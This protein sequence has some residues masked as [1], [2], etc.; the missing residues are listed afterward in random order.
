MGQ[1]QEDTL[2]ITLLGA[3]Q[4]VPV[5]ELAMETS[6][7]SDR[8]LRRVSISFDVAAD[9]S[10]ELN[11]ELSAAQDAEQPLSGG[12]VQWQVLNSSYSSYS[13][14]EGDSTHHHDV[15][16][17]EVEEPPKAQSLEMLDLFLQPRK[18]KEKADL[19]LIHR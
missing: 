13:Y 17:Q 3:E 18:Y 16:L 1:N 7:Y 9:R 2:R 4:V 11:R 6:P 19:A 5:V 8:Q 14:Q 10:D 15:E 12:G